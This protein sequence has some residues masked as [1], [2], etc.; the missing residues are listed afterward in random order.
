[1]D[2]SCGVR[3]GDARRNLNCQVERFWNAQRSALEP[4]TK[5]AAGNVLHGD[6]PASVRRVP[7]RENRGYVRVAQRR[8]RARFLLE[9]L[10]SAKVIREVFSQ[11]L[12]RHRATEPRLAS[13]IHF[14]HR[15]PPQLAENL[16]PAELNAGRHMH[17]AGLYQ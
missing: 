7:S 3:R 4:L 6:E 1:M 12:D 15:S 8:G 5:R 13:E 17:A 16:V 10:H 2:D 11:Q 14:A 9:P